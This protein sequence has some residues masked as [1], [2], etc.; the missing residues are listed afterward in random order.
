VDT[1][2]AREL[3]DLSGLSDSDLWGRA[4]GSD[5][6]AFTAVYERFADRIYNFCFRRS[7]SWA[8]AEDLTSVVFLEAWRRRADV[9]LDEHDSPLPWLYGVATNVLRNRERGLR[10]HAAALGRI[11]DRVEGFAVVE[12]DPA[13][14]VAGRLDDERR[15]V[16]VLEALDQLPARDRDVLT[17][18]VW[19]GLDYASA[20]VALGVPVGTVRSRLA[21]ARGRLRSS[22]LED[23]RKESGS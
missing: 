3:R 2:P 20:A 8:D 19:E 6:A 9:V 13:D 4:G 23:S 21:R 16:E 7:G 1:A 5:P 12:P 18:C 17:L 15:M 11:H 10:R 14:E 22:L